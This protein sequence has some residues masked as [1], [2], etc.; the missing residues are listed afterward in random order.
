MKLAQAAQT[1]IQHAQHGPAEKP[2]Q[3][4][5]NRLSPHF[6]QLITEVMRSHQIATAKDAIAEVSVELENLKA[7]MPEVLARHVDFTQARI[8]AILNHIY[9]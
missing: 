7:L 2:G 8:T 1:I 9:K 5:V 3:R 4:V 6:E